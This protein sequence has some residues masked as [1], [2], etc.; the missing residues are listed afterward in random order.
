MFEK[1]EKI[2][3]ENQMEPVV[4][5][6]KRVDDTIKTDEVPGKKRRRPGPLPWLLLIVG[7]CVGVLGGF[8]LRPLV[9]PEDVEA[10]AAPVVEAKGLDG[11]DRQF[12]T[13]L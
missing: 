4:R 3:A 5:T 12:A 7:L 6:G 1:D 13:R 8:Y 11:A 9:M 2:V 10:S